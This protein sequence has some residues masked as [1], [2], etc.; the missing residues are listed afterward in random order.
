MD[1]TRLRPGRGRKVVHVHN[2]QD[3]CSQYKFPP[4]ATGHE[5][6]GEEVAGHLDGLFGRFGPP[7]FCKRDNG[8]NVNHVAVDDVLGE[9][10]VIPINS[11][12][13]RAPYN[14]AIEHS[15]GEMKRYL[16][17]WQDKAKT[18]TEMVLL[19]ETAAH[20]LNH[21]HRRSLAGRTSCLRYFA[22]PRVR[23]G[24]RERSRIYHWIE[25]LAYRISEGM[26]KTALDPTAWRVAAKTWMVKN[27]LI[28]ILRP[29]KVLPNLST[30]LCHH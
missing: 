22:G 24:K 23:Y 19:T 21:I 28:T 2:L 20:D 18:L 7:L 27:N 4:L 29:G 9:A 14:G 17:K 3:L 25:E 8:G 11:P 10:M 13:D 1:G 30:G 6:L 16:K 26:G 12:V 5:A 15:Q